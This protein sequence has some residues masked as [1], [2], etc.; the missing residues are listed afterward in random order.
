M[1]STIVMSGGRAVETADRKAIIFDL[2]PEREAFERWQ[3]GKFLDVERLF[4]KTWRSFLRLSSLTLFQTI[5]TTAKVLPKCHSLEEA[6]LVAESIIGLEENQQNLIPLI[7]ELLHINKK[8][9]PEV[10]ERWA[11]KN[12]PP[13]KEFSPYAAYVLI[14]EIF[15]YLA[16]NSGLV[17]KQIN[18]KTD[19]AYLYYLPFC[20]VFVSSDNLHRR[21]APLF[22]RK[23]QDFVWGLDLKEDLRK[24]D[25]FYD[26]LPIAEKEKGLYVMAVYP[27]KDESFLTTRLWDRFLPKWREHEKE[28]PV[29]KNKED[30]KRIVKEIIKIAEGK[31]LELNMVDFDSKNTDAMIVKRSVRK[32]KGKWWQVPKDLGSKD[33]PLS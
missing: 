5:F 18:S 30:E 1:N 26:A 17:S 25:R 27:P 20:M 19:F 6:K 8:Y 14:I 23:D 32:K 15:F 22:L 2:P 11:A 33:A 10:N 13:L 21:C 3:K 31:T 24:I 9:I 4:A 16:I 28:R 12:F 29:V 7:F